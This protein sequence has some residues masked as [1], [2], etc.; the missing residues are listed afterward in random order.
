MKM[1]GFFIVGGLIGAMFLS[2]ERAPAQDRYYDSTIR[3]IENLVQEVNSPGAAV[4]DAPSAFAR[5]FCQ[6][7][8]NGAAQNDATRSG[9]AAVVAFYVE[10]YG[11]L[12]AQRAV[13]SMTNSDHQAI[14]R[15]AINACPDL[16]N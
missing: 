10:Q 6:A 14:A 8:R 11:A 16:I 2:A 5:A 12:G 7:R 9:S 15:A 13:A 4:V 3:Q 1:N